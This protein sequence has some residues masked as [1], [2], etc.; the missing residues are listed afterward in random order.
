MPS[1]FR[2]CRCITRNNWALES[3]VSMAT[4]S[5]MRH[6]VPLEH[7]RPTVGED[8]DCHVDQLVGRR[9]VALVLAVVV[10][11]IGTATLADELRS[12]DERLHFLYLLAESLV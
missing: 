5:A 3:A 7:A 10:V 1:S 9:K 8:S 2:C 11:V 4:T 12:E 6:L